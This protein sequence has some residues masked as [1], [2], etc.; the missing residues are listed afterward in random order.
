LVEEIERKE[1]VI[2]QDFRITEDM[3]IKEALWNERMKTDGGK[4]R[5]ARL[6]KGWTSRRLAAALGISQT[7][8][9]LMEKNHRPLINKALDFIGTSAR[10]TGEEGH[11]SNHQPIE[12]KQVT[13][14]K[15]MGQ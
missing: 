14:T 5:M 15:N 1:K 10:P 13:D 7:Y 6:Q 2:G 11:F 4:L 8:I 9:V 12:N 3:K